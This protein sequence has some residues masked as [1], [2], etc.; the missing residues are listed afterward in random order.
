MVCA[1]PGLDL[2]AALEEMVDHE[3]E[4]S[5]ASFSRNVFGG[6]K[7]FFHLCLYLGLQVSIYVP[8]SPDLNF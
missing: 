5:S 8:S 1:G 7:L 6:T 4:K 2:D 3:K